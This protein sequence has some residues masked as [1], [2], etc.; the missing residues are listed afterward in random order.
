MFQILTNLKH[1]QL[2]RFSDLVNSN[3]CINFP[4]KGE[5]RSNQNKKHSLATWEGIV[6]FCQ[7]LLVN[8][9]INHYLGTVGNVLN[10]VTKT[11]VCIKI[12]IFQC[13]ILACSTLFLCSFSYPKHCTFPFTSQPGFFLLLLS[14]LL[15]KVSL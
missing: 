4:S 7:T 10:M 1:L 5:F 13:R 15:Y 8:M 14:R 9:L 3:I 11:I 12:F 2:A 6:K